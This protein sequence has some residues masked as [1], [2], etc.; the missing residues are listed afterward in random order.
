[1]VVMYR[2]LIE[3]GWTH[4]FRVIVAG[5][6]P[7]RIHAVYIHIH[8]HIRVHVRCRSRIIGCINDKGESQSLFGLGRWGSLSGNKS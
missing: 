8:I 5:T 6:M 1:M 7:Y 2:Q 3:V 4:L